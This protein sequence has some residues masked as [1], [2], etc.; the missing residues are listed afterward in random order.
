[1][2]GGGVEH[3]ANKG[4]TAPPPPSPLH[5]ISG[6]IHCFHA[7]LMC[8]ASALARSTS[9]YSTPRVHLR[10]AIRDIARAPPTHAN[11]RPI[12]QVDLTLLEIAARCDDRLPWGESW[13]SETA[14]KC[15]GGRDNLIRNLTR[16]VRNVTRLVRNASHVQ[17]KA[18]LS[19]HAQVIP[20]AGNQSRRR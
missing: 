9:I 13:I 19:S 18:R 20:D 12:S 14:P 6:P 16:P 5:A 17:R 4:T 1:V 7:K 11:P 8:N 3:G 15:A 2:W 10:C